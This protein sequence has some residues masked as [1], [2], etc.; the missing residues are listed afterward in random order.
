MSSEK[1]WPFSK[2]KI[3]QK[4]VTY[5]PMLNL[6]K[7]QLQVIQNNV[8]ATK[9]SGTKESK[10]SKNRVKVMVIL[11]TTGPVIDSISKTTTKTSQPNK[12]TESM[13]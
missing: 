7:I 2:M 3:F 9:T 6:V 13:S 4:R 11:A 5:V 8:S 1:A 12:D 10:K